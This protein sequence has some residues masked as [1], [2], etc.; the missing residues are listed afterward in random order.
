MQLADWLE[1]QEKTQEWLADEL[2]VTQGRISQ[3][4]RKGTDSLSLAEKIERKTGGAV[5]M[6]ELMQKRP[7]GVEQA[8]E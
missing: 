3:V 5:T 7:S 8:A 6:R 2:G 1:A 4:A